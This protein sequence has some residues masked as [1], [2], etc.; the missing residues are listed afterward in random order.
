MWHL[1]HAVGFNGKLIIPEGVVYIGQSTFSGCS[2]INGDLTI[3]SSVEKIEDS[4][5]ENCKEINGTLTIGMKKIPGAST[6]FESIRPCKLVIKNTVET[7]EDGKYGSG[8]FALKNLT[9]GIVIEKG[10]K[11]IGKHAFNYIEISGDLIIPDSVTTLEE[12][13]FNG[14]KVTGKIEIPNSITK[15]V[16]GCFSNCNSNKLI[17]GIRDIPKETFVVGKFD[18]IILN[19]T[20]ER[21]GQEAFAGSWINGDLIIP[22]SIKE[23]TDGFY[24]A[25]FKGNITVRM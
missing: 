24:G 16:N 6:L 17:I 3:P 14:A 18:E 1:C 15:I 10:V 2:R 19:N 23:M 20:V 21:I 13:A 22:S 12:G 11:Y 4:A 8:A 5:F 7:I 9:K 25:S